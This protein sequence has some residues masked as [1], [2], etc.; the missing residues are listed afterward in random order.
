MSIDTQFIS[1]KPTNKYTPNYIHLKRITFAEYNFIYHINDGYS[2]ND[3]SK[4]SNK[5][6]LLFQKIS[7]KVMQMNLMIVDSIFPLL[8]ADVVLDTF[9]KGVSSFHQYTV[10]KDKIIISDTEFGSEYLKYK[11]WYFIHHL[12]YSDIAGKKIYKG[13]IDS[14]N[15]YYLKNDKNEIQYFSILEQNQLQELMFHKMNLEIVSEKSFTAKDKA[16]ICFRIF[17]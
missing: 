13:E 1:P 6:Q 3:L 17:Y 14:S 7:S 12:L 5:T 4:F 8:L 11:F 2:I 16:N 15:I 10:S 9:L